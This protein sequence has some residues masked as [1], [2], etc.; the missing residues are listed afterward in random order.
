[1]TMQTLAIHVLCACFG[2]A[3]AHT[4]FYFVIGNGSLGLYYL[5]VCALL[6]LIFALLPL[7]EF[8][9]KDENDV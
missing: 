7:P 9:R 1:M 4:V 6:A 3:F 8:N 5:G 2:V